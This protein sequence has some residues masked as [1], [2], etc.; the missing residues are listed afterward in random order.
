M[1]NIKE[2]ANSDNSAKG[3][4]G[5]TLITKPLLAVVYKYQDDFIP[6]LTALA[7][8]LESGASTLN[9]EESSEAERYVSHAL[10]DASDGLNQACEKLESRDMNAL[11]TFLSSVAAKNPSIMFSTSYIA[12]VIFGRLG[13]HIAHQKMMTDEPPEFDQFLH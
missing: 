7:K 6:Y 13:R 8:G 12:G 10:Q 2:K 11:S 4:N 9:R 1:M 3:A 5:L